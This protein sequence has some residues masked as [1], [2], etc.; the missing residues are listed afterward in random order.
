MIAPNDGR[1]HAQFRTGRRISGWGAQL[2]K[3]V[4]QDRL[5]LTFD[6]ALTQLVA[7]ELLLNDL[8]SVVAKVDFSW[9]RRLLHAGR[10]IGR[11][12]YRRVVHAQVIADSAHHYVPGVQSDSQ[13]EIPMQVIEIAG[14]GLDCLL[15]GEGC[16]RRAISVVFVCKWCSEQGHEPVAQELVNRSPIAV[17]LS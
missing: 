2:P 8:M 14:L 3:A 1:A 12:A 17:Y 4:H 10:E 11:I 9:W 13:V 5:G 16:A 7:F 6:L 15:K